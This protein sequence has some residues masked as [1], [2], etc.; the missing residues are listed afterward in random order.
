MAGREEEE[1]IR[2]KGKELWQALKSDPLD[3]QRVKLLLEF[4]ASANFREPGSH[5]V[6]CKID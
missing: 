6:S 5:K 3:N 4:G 2:R 1:D